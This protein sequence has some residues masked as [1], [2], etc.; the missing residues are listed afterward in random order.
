MVTP[1]LSD[2]ALL[3]SQHHG[4]PGADPR[5][6]SHLRLEIVS[7]RFRGLSRVARQQMVYALLASEMHERIHA[8]SMRTLTPEEETT[9]QEPF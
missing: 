4:H 2:E 3:S 1:K 5:G 9:K 8:L 6:E 7:E